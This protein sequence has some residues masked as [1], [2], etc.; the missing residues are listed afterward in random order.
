MQV[1]RG[2]LTLM[3]LGIFGYTAAVIAKDGINFVTPFLT[4]LWAVDWQGQF[5]F[6]FLFY[7]V[8]SGLWVG[9]RHGFAGTGLVLAL[10]CGF[11]MVY[12]APYLLVQVMR[13]QDVRALVLGPQA[14]E[15]AQ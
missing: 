9:W 5:N 12:F 10:L 1:L 4:G 3:T 2:V 11:G 13:A 8:L 7:L 14:K 15:G 6:D